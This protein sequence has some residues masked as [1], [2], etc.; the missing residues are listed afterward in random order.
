MKRLDPVLE[1][2][3]EPDHK[4]PEEM[5]MAS[6]NSN[7]TKLKTQPKLTHAEVQRLSER[8]ASILENDSEDVAILTLLFDHIERTYE[9]RGDVY[10]IIFTVKKYLFAGLDEADQARDQFQA[11]AYANRGKLLRWPE[12]RSAK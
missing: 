2:Q 4:H 5:I 6:T 1:H 11:D 12:E 3:A 7:V 9:E 8:L 10:D